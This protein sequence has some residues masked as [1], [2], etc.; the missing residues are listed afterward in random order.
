MCVL[1]S[2]RQVARAFDKPLVLDTSSVT[3]VRYMFYVRYSRALALCSR[4]HLNAHAQ[5]EPP[6]HALIL[7]WQFARAFNQLL[8]FDTG[9][10][11]TMS[12]MFKVRPA[13]RMACQSRPS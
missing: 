13:A 8:S 1:L 5:L 10:V 6:S 12:S 4:A 11:T 9:R 2:A 3:D 7:A